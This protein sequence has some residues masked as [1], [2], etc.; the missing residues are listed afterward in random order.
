MKNIEKGTFEVAVKR[1]GLGYR[2]IQYL[3]LFAACTIAYGMRTVLNVAIIAILSNDKKDRN[4]P[5][6]P[7]WASKKNIMLSSFFW[8]YICLQI[9][10]GQLAKNYGPKLFL[11]A[12]IFITSLFTLLT[13]YMGA[14]IGY[15]GIILCRIIQ[16]LSQGFLV[17]SIHNL[18]SHWAPATER[19]TWGSG[20]YAGQALGNVLAM[21]ITGLISDSKYGWPAAFYLYG[22]LGICW[23]I[24]W[25][26]FG[27]DSPA[28]HKSISSDEKQYIESSIV[29]EKDSPDVPTPWKSIFT[30]L[31]MIS[32]IVAHCG[33]NWGFWTLLTEIPSFMEKILKQN[34]TSNSLLSALPYFVMWVMTFVFS[35]LADMI[36]DKKIVRLITS[37][38]IF[39]T[40]GLGCPAITLLTLIW[41]DS[42]W[43]TIAVLVIA[44]G[45]NAAQYSG[46]NINHIDLSPVHAGTMMAITNSAAT[47][48]SI[49]AP[50]AVDL[51][52]YISGYEETDVAL[53]NIVFC[54]TSTFYLL[55]T[56]F[57]ICFASGD[58]Q[59]WNFNGSTPPTPPQDD[60]IKIKVLR[61]ISTLSTA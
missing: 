4:Y 58:V 61:K 40:I 53:W 23:S 30:S 48:C 7:N 16:G 29:T 21:P 32:L 33:Q 49:L 31:P 38:K 15:G 60:D 57:Y 17:P 27:S 50:L 19:A 25:I 26:I 11:F 6:Y 34:I 9:G 45:F 20:V 5:V 42:K 52:I 13:P 28:K 1:S 36:V 59:K 56:I 41:I 24:L 12:A 46:F 39:N 43:G 55:A 3:L 37:R 35:P 47:V 54:T 51:F 2:H 14:L 10:A 8:G 44:M 22:A 18:L